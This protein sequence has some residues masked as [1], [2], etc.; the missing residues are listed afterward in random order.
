MEMWGW[1]ESLTNWSR[2]QIDI[3]RK[4]WRNSSLKTYQMA[5]QKWCD[6]AVLNSVS[7]NKPKGADLAR[8]L[9][10]L[11]QCQG[12]AYNTI[13]LY[14]SAISTLCDPNL[15][16]RLS[17]HL[18]VKQVLKSL[19]LLKPLP[20]KV[21]IWDTDVLVNWLKSKCPD[22]NSLYES[23]VRAAILLLLC[24]G[25]RVH[26]LTLLAIGEENCSFLDNCVVFWPKYGSKTDTSDHRQSGW[27][28]FSNDDCKEL[29]PLFWIEKV[30]TLSR[31]R[32]IR[33]G[34]DSLFLTVCGAPKKASRSNIAG[35]I[36]KELLRAG[37]KA[38]AGSVRPAVASKSWVQNC[39]LDEILAR[40]NWRTESTFHKFYRREIRPIGTQGDSLTHL[41]KTS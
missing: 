2:S 34:E 18:L 40:G 38:S 21:P 32:R 1:T 22:I 29:N 8:F 9:I 30:V 39:P 12:L 26:D 20:E 15:T 37:I 3:L 14:K 25:R 11:H 7:L 41:F 5:W 13:L 28:I 16:N 33:C 17:S 36:R 35:W 23:S 31:Q 6:W 10:D 27:R 4:S 19:K 24:S